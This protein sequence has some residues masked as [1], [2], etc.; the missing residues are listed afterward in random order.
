MYS[1]QVSALLTSE[2]FGLTQEAYS[3]SAFPTES[4]VEFTGL[5]PWT[6]QKPNLQFGEKLNQS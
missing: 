5:S 3:T 1:E 4:T 2:F 6:L